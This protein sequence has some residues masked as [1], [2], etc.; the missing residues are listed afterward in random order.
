MSNRRADEDPPELTLVGEAEVSVQQQCGRSF[1]MVS[2]PCVAGSYTDPGATAL[3]AVDGDVSS[4][5]TVQGTIDL[6]TAGVQQLTYTASDSQGLSA[7]QVRT[8]TVVG[9]GCLDSTCV[10]SRLSAPLLFVARLFL[11]LLSVNLTYSLRVPRRMYNYD[12]GASVQGDA[13]CVAFAFGCTGSSGH[14]YD[15]DANSGHCRFGDS[16]TGVAVSASADS[17]AYPNVQFSYQNLDG[18]C[19]CA[20]GFSGNYC[21][22]NVDGCAAQPCENGGVCHDSS[23]GYFCDCSQTDYL[24][25]NCQLA[26]EDCSDGA[27]SCGSGSA[28]CKQLQGESTPECLCP[29][30][31]IAEVC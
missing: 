10:K 29:F 3:D 7:S 6:T 24:G 13:E 18:W 19:V 4:S 14:N 8:V 28:T 21:D 5:I 15:S 1:Q 30:G 22:V 23:P 20:D 9:V 31:E 2:D 25:T 12:Y 27:S 26:A 16:C 11:S 17:Q